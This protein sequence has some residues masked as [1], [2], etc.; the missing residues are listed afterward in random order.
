MLPCG[1]GALGLCP[2]SEP[3]A[4][5]QGA[6]RAAGQGSRLSALFCLQDG[7][8][9]G[10]PRE[11]AEG[12][13]LHKPQAA[14]VLRERLP[15]TFSPRRTRRSSAAWS[16]PCRTSCALASVGRCQTRTP[17][18]CGRWDGR[19]PLWNRPPDTRPEEGL[20][21]NASAPG[22][23]EVQRLRLGSCQSGNQGIVVFLRPRADRLG[24][25][26]ADLGSPRNASQGR[27]C[28]ITHAPMSGHCKGL[29][30]SCFHFRIY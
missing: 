22:R 8:G 4:G 18:S 11:M 10:S 21:G 6:L 30:H 28:P 9:F 14:S 16:A 3:R 19:N 7:R 5:E 2:A 20:P 24:I 15:R 12:G 17:G 29:S 27:M 25:R 23:E 1:P 13:R 26:D